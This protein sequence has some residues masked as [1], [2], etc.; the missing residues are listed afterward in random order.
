M[1]RNAIQ[2]FLA[3]SGLFLCAG[4]MNGIAHAQGQSIER[5]FEATFAKDA[6]PRKSGGLAGSEGD[7]K[8][9]LMFLADWEGGC[10]AMYKRYV[11]ASGH[12][13]FAATTVDYFGGGGFVCGAGYNAGSQGKAEAVAM[14]QC[15]EARQR[16]KVEQ[17]GSCV[18]YASK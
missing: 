17:I 16:Y 11:A 4:A 14:A 1:R 8:R 5:R 7:V 15:K 18:V 12:S 2:V 13:A 3:I 6:K 9:K 10:G